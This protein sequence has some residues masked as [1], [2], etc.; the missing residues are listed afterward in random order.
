MNIYEAF[1]QIKASHESLDEYEDEDENSAKESI[2]LG[3][4]Y[5]PSNI[6]LPFFMIELTYTPPSHSHQIDSEGCYID[7]EYYRASTKLCDLPETHQTIV[8]SF[9]RNSIDELVRCLPDI[10]ANLNYQSYEVDTNAF[11]GELRRQIKE[12]FPALTSREKDSLKKEAIE[13]I[14]NLNSSK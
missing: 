12:I 2:T 1:E 3:I 5:D 14:N 4:S 13:A 10:A 6:D 9:F 11:D 7:D 8:N